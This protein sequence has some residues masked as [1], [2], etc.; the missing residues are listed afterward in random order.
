MQPVPNVSDADVERIVRRDFPASA[1]ADVMSILQMYGRETWEQ[2]PARVRVATLKL[3]NG[4]VS[5]LRRHIDVAKRDFRDV[6]AAAEYPAAVREWPAANDGGP[7]DRQET[8]DADWNQYRR[9]FE[10]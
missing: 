10:R 5:A 3:A 2:E 9:W 4:D 1:F 6:L 7:N 8:F